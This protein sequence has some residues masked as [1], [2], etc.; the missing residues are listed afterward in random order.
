MRL[1]SEMEEGST[2]KHTEGVRDSIRNAFGQSAIKYLTELL[3]DV[4]GG[5]MTNDTSM[6]LYQK[7]LGK[8]NRVAVAANLR[9]A[10]LQPLAIIRAGN[11]LPGTSLASGTL[12]CRHTAALPCGR[13]LDIGK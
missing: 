12:R 8:Y 6:N 4:N 5:A 7:A 3:K 13:T 10:M 9:V 1:E 11:E 2:A